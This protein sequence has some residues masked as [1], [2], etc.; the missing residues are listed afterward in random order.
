MSNCWKQ[1]QGRGRYDCS[2]Q[3][4]LNVSLGGRPAYVLKAVFF[5]RE[6]ISLLP[7]EI[8][9]LPLVE[10]KQK[11]HLVPWECLYICIYFDSECYV[12]LECPLDQ[13]RGQEPLD[14]KR[15]EM[16]QWSREQSKGLGAR[17]KILPEARNGGATGLWLIR[18]IWVLLKWGGGTAQWGAPCAIEDYVRYILERGRHRHVDWCFQKPICRSDNNEFLQIASVITDFMFIQRSPNKGT[19]FVK[20]RWILWSFV[21]KGSHCIDSE[22]QQPCI[23]SLNRIVPLTRLDHFFLVLSLNHCPISNGHIIGSQSMFVVAGIKIIFLLSFHSFPASP[24]PCIS[25]GKI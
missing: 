21:V 23:L 13:Q 10:F 4:C 11:S 2:S 15:W 14:W 17:N 7:N 9:Y 18:W 19:S 1:G 5:K 16:G 12:R 6:W 8:V 20:S 24:S 22:F 3:G 25:S